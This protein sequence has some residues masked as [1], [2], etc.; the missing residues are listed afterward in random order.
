MH[1]TFIGEELHKVD[2]KGR[3]SIPSPFRKVIEVGDTERAEGSPS[4]FILV[5]GNETRNY[6]EGFPLSVHARLM[7][8]IARLPRNDPRRR[9]YERF[10]SGYAVQLTL[11]ENGRIVLPK[12][13]RDK[14]GLSGNVYFIADNDTF[15]IWE[16]ETYEKIH[17]FEDGEDDFDPDADPVPL[18]DFEL[19]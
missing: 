15:Q 18:T 6:L 13:L 8:S 12:K 19:D 14:I 16:P 2:T 3:V 5:Y 4:S 1:A 10:Y 11:D 17:G 9:N 7:K